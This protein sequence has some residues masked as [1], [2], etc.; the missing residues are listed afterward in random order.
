MLLNDK[1]QNLYK[2]Q[3]P[4]FDK[5]EA[6][7]QSADLRSPETASFC[8]STPLHGRIFFFLPTLHYR[9]LETDEKKL[10]ERCKQIMKAN[11]KERRT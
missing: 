3:N 10:P 8:N 11:N 4:D 1:T 9:I 6:W 7:G 2:K 5:S